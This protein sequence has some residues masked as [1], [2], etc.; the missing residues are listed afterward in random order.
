MTKKKIIEELTAPKW[1]WPLDESIKAPPIG[2]EDGTIKDRSPIF[3]GVTKNQWVLLQS[4]D[5]SQNLNLTKALK[6]GLQAAEIHIKSGDMEEIS[7]ILNGIQPHMLEMHFVTEKL[8][9]ALKLA[10]NLAQFYK[11]LGINSKSCEGSIRI[12]GEIP[13]TGELKIISDQFPMKKWMEF[14]SSRDLMEDQ[15]V[16]QLERVF[17]PLLLKLDKGEITPEQMVEKSIFRL[18]IGKNLIS[19]ITKIRSF[20]RLWSLVCD[21]LNINPIP[22]PQLECSIRPDIMEEN[23]YHNLIR[24]TTVAISAVIGGVKR[25]HLPSECLGSSEE[26]SDAENF[27]R[28]MNTNISHILEKES[29]FGKVLDPVSGSYLIEELT[30]KL[31]ESTWKKIRESL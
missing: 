16:A 28:R 23:I 3:Y 4:F 31:A 7:A 5:S 8:E 10:K 24:S 12:R 27:S 14:S 22:E 17:V 18:Y 21:E 1:E 13:N 19:E 6:V 29:H 9:T 30:E 2:F 11:K 15:R 26:F 25:I 20:H